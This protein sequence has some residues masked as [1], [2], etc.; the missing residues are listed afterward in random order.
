MMR[1]SIKMENISLL[2]LQENFES[3]FTEKEFT[4][5]KIQ[6]ENEVFDCHQFI[7]SARSP[8]FKAM[9]QADMNEKGR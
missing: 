8:V 3:A 7:L 5:I 2:K 1:V 4:D 9:F 6:C